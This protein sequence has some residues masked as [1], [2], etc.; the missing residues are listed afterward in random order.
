MSRHLSPHPHH[1][2]H[3]TLLHKPRLL[4]RNILQSIRHL[5][6]PPHLPKSH[7]PALLLQKVSP[8]ILHLIVPP[9][10]R[11]LHLR[12]ENPRPQFQLPQILAGPQ[13]PECDK[14]ST[15]QVHVA[16]FAEQAAALDADGFEELEHRPDVVEFEAV[17]REIDVGSFLVDLAAGEQEGKVAV[18]AGVLPE[19]FGEGAGGADV[20]GADEEEGID[21]VARIGKL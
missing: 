15:P 12:R 17:A 18:L 2:L 19:G 21:H 14:G 6:M 11:L 3:Q 10:T 9:A 20:G 16:Y 13:I 7:L 4:D 1:F 8:R 5:P